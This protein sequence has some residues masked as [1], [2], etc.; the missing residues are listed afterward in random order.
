MDYGA[1]VTVVNHQGSALDILVHAS[2]DDILFEEMK[3]L[4]SKIELR[5][6][7]PRLFWHLINHNNVKSAQF[8]FDYNPDLYDRELITYTLLE[9]LEE[10][11]T[12]DL[13]TVEF[14]LNKNADVSRIQHYTHLNLVLENNID[15]AILLIKYGAD[16][17]G[18]DNTYRE[19]VAEQ[20]AKYQQLNNLINDIDF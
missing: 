9:Y 13:E 4:I 12:V 1:D 2:H 16:P 17:N 3:L 18:I 5:I 8:L 14:L 19:Y 15:V 11:K 7:G 6:F 20:L 10:K